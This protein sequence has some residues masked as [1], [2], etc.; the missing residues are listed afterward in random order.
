MYPYLHVK[1]IRFHSVGQVQVTTRTVSTHSLCE[2]NVFGVKRSPTLKQRNNLQSLQRSTRQLHSRPRHCQATT[3]RDHDDFNDLRWRAEKK[4]NELATVSN[5]NIS[6]LSCNPG[7]VSLFVVEHNYTPKQTI[8]ELQMIS[9]MPPGLCGKQLFLSI[10]DHSMG[11]GG[12]KHLYQFNLIQFNPI[13]VSK[14]LT[15]H[16]F[17]T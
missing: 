7:N 11:G 10:K 5:T 13:A 8:K 4:K 14:C 2:K 12:V 3:F 9:Q 17:I 6:N 16:T 1:G 15:G